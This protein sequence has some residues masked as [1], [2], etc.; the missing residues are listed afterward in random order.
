MQPTHI[1]KS[2]VA[3]EVP[4]P[5]RQSNY[6]EPFASLVQGRIKRRLGEPFGLSGFGVNLVCL[7]PGSASS[8]KHWHTR[9]DEFIYVLSGA[10]VLTVGDERTQLHAGECAGFPAGVPVGHCLKNE[11]SEDA[12]YLEIGSRVEGDQAHYP[13][14]DLALTRHQGNYVFTRKDG[15]PYSSSD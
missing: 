13:D 4:V 12:W 7:Q 9:E 8:V 6:P 15:T 3:A 1:P 2:L 10:L 14:D 5:A 11:S